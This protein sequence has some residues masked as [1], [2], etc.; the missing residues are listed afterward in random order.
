M[1][2]HELAKILLALPDLQVATHANNHCFAPL[3]GQEREFAVAHL[4]K[5]ESEFVVIG[6]MGRTETSLPLEYIDEVYHGRIMKRWPYVDATTGKW[7]FPTEFLE[8]KVE[9]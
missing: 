8:G 9:V 5:G 6:N 2:S 7:V 4:K 3:Q 1:R